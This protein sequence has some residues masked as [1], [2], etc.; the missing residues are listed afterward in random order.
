MPREVQHAYKSCFDLDNMLQ[1]KASDYIALTAVVVKAFDTKSNETGDSFY[2]SL[3]VSDTMA[4]QGKLWVSL[5]S[6]ERKYLDNIRLGNK[7]V[8]RGFLNINNQ[9][10]AVSIGNAYATRVRVNSTPMANTNYNPRSFVVGMMFKQG[11]LSFASSTFANSDWDSNVKE[12]GAR[13]DC[14]TRTITAER[15][16][17]LLA[18]ANPVQKT[19]TKEPL[20]GDAFEKVN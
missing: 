14:V 17:A 15:V 16:D 20:D 13:M 8:F 4:A 18:C 7:Y 10:G 5:R 6:N 11:M 19:E 2:R 1:S 12:I 9:T 3:F